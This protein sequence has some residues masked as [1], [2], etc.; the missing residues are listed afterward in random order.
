MDAE[1]YFSCDSLIA[2]ST[3]FGFRLR[4][5]TVKWKWTLVNT[6][7][8]GFRPFRLQRHIAAAHIL[9]ALAQNQHHIIGGAAAGA[10]QY[11]LH[12]PWRQIAA[13]ALRR[14]IHRDQMTGAGLG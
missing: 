3:R 5:L 2:R 11:Q 12:R 1:Q 6:L 9:P 4:P 13:A 8:L 10:G 7:G 14:A